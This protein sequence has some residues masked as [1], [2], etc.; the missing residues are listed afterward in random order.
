MKA[1]SDNKQC[2]LVYSS[3]DS[4]LKL[5]DYRTVTNSNPKL[6]IID[7]ALY[8]GAEFSTA[9]INID[10][11]CSRFR[12]NGNLFSGLKDDETAVKDTLPVS[13]TNLVNPVFSADFSILV[14]DDKILT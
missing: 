3:D 10:D 8:T 4:K 12:I 14:T 9:E 5:Y 11:T 7:S 13:V 2:A 1:V 6:I